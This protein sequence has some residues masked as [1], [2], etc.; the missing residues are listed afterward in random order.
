MPA[1]DLKE[2]L[3]EL[4]IDEKELTEALIDRIKKLIRLTKDGGV[5]F[6]IPKDELSIKSQVMLYLLGKKM[7]RDADL[8]SSEVASIDEISGA[9]GADYFTVAARLNELK[10]EGLVLTV[11]RGGY[12]I[13]PANINKILDEVEKGRG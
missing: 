10:K 13:Q 2:K 3:R 12:T 7:A 11:E 1:E 5:V 6:M 4:I 8:V 9:I